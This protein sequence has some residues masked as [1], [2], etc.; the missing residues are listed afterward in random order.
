MAAKFNLRQILCLWRLWKRIRNRQSK[1]KLR[2]LKKPSICR[3]DE[4]E[5]FQLVKELYFDDH[6]TFFKYFRMSPAN[7]DYL[8]SL[9]EKSIKRKP[10]SRGYVSPRDDILFFIAALVGC[11]EYL[12]S[13]SRCCMR[14]QPYPAVTIYPHC[15][16][17]ACGSMLYCRA[18]R[19]EENIT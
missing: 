14:L 12:L 16:L 5:E 11:A 10:S 15:S 6:E 3:R 9:V 7:C 13:A 19:L 18:R 8:L 4:M 1:R 17:Q 2:Y